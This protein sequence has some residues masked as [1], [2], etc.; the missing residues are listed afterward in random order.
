M[1]DKLPYKVGEFHDVQQ[2]T[3]APRPLEA[4]PGGRRGPTRGAQDPLNRCLGA[5]LAARGRMG[6]G[7][8]APGKRVVGGDRGLRIPACSASPCATV[9][10][11]GR[12]SG[13][14]CTELAGVGRQ[15]APGRGLG[16]LT[17]AGT[18]TREFGSSLQDLDRSLGHWVVPDK[19]P[20]LSGPPMGKVRALKPLRVCEERPGE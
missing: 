2:A 3:S 7:V 13:V 6:I 20:S 15:C 5:I 9:R 18:Y 12:S 8:L 11:A 16:P 1:S 14:L 17:P 10:T 4:C 19:C